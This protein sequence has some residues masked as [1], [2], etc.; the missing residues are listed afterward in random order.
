[1]AFVTNNDIYHVRDSLCRNPNLALVAPQS[2]HT[3][4]EHSHVF[5]DAV[6][7]QGQVFFR[8]TL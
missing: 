2:P 4:L 7:Q 8:Q 5:F 3:R 6:S 1:M